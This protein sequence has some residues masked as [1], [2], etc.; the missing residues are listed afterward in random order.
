MKRFVILVALLVA[1]C[2][3]VER[4]AAG[5]P[6]PPAEVS[7]TCADD[8]KDLADVLFEMDSRLKV[9]MNFQA[10]G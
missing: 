3:G 9:G 8:V 10:Y 2:G 1:G 4:D 6:I 7:S 5:S